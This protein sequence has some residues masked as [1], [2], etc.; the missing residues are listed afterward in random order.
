[1]EA[2]P[3][4]RTLR[5]D[6]KDPKCN[7]GKRMRTVFYLKMHGGK[8]AIDAL[9]G[10][11]VSESVLLNH[12]ICY[13]LGQM[14]DPQALPVL[15]AVLED[16]KAHPV[17][18]HEAAEALGAIG[19]EKSIELLEK[20][21]DSKVTEVAETCKLAIDTIKHSLALAEKKKKEN[22]E[23]DGD[24]AP[25]SKYLSVD[26]APAEEGETSPEKLQ[27]TLTDTTIS[28]FHRY[29]AMFAL[30]DLGT[31]EAVKALAVAFEDKSAIV[32]HEPM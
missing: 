16:E 9:A 15:N 14:Q 26:P 17:V 23:N 5:D 21:K 24:D 29:R 20:Y 22:A 10:G 13:V 7:I 25:S 2:P 19:M 12:E 31:E 4:I 3:P 1:M 28:L 27:K 8:E 6:L 32:R 18:R 30:R 11:L